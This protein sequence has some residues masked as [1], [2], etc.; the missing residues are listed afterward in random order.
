[1]GKLIGVT[2]TRRK[3]IKPRGTGHGA[4]GPGGK[5]GNGHAREHRIQAKTGH[6]ARPPGHTRQGT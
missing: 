3:G 5:R 6:G 1:M 4:P 2:G